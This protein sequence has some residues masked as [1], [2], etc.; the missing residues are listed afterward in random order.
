M[1][2]SAES[3]S[4]SNRLRLQYRYLNFLEHTRNKENLYFKPDLPDSFYMD[5]FKKIG[6]LALVYNRNRKFVI[7][8]CSWLVSR[9]LFHSG[10]GTH[11][12]PNCL[13][14][15]LVI[16]MRYK[17]R[18]LSSFCQHAGLWARCPKSLP[19]RKVSNESV[20][21]PDETSFVSGLATTAM[22]HHKLVTVNFIVNT[23]LQLL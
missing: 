13:P 20:G 15:S 10:Q 1:C 7:I 8:Y 22:Y 3:F 11:Q 14:N 18:L 16:F 9:N 19:S 17:A 12:R 23:K 6:I 5:T 2:V 4:W 21:Q